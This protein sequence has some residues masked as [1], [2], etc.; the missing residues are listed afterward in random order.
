MSGGRQVAVTG[1]GA[2]APGGFNS[3][4]AAW[5]GRLQRKKRNRT[6]VPL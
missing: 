1:L 2:L 4:D 6:T 5:Q 3:A